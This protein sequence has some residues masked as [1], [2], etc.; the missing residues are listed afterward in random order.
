MMNL[1]NFI[2]SIGSGLMSLR[3]KLAKSFI[4]EYRAKTGDY[5][6]DEFHAYYKAFIKAY[7]EKYNDYSTKD[8]KIFVESFR[9]FRIVP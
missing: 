5:T 2:D 3:L 1:E 4:S 7:R 6:S 8:Y 9:L